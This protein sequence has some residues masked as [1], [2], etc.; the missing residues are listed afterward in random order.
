MAVSL[1]PVFAP[2]IWGPYFSAMIPGMWLSEGGQSATGK[3]I[4][5]IID[6]HP[7]SAS[8]KTKL[9]DMLVSLFFFR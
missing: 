7:A 6:S 4:D 3:L 1:T 2:G 8:I 9:G 5:H